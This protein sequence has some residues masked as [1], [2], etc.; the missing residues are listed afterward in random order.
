MNP[1]LKLLDRTTFCEHCVINEDG[2]HQEYCKVE[3][4]RRARV[5]QMLV[6]QKN[7]ITIELDAA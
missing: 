6:N 5:L 7:E 2:S 4:D 1:H 3:I